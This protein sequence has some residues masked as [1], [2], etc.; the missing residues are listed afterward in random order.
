[1][2]SNEPGADFV[3]AAPLYDTFADHVEGGTPT[4]AP[5]PGRF[6]DLAPVTLQPPLYYREGDLHYTT[7]GSA[8]T[9]QSPVY[10]ER[11]M[12]TGDTEL[13]ACEFD[14]QG[15][16]GAVWSGHYQVDDVH[17]PA[18]VSVSSAPL[19][20]EVQI[21]FSKPVQPASARDVGHYVFTTDA[22]GLLG[23]GAMLIKSAQPSGD[24]TKVTLLLG[25]PLPQDAP[26]ILGVRDIV[27][28]SPQANVLEVFRKSRGWAAAGV[29]RR[30][31]A[32]STAVPV[33]GE[34]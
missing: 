27:E 34:R 7:D 18:V 31:A 20:P 23:S 21:S 15:R 11:L 2:P 29:C 1:M 26:V 14:A 5:A 12:L 17:P 25:A 19:M 22:H 9:L 16:P 8:P 24:G 4:A 28:A 6:T 10:T 3:A 33:R 30:F 32:L 13:K